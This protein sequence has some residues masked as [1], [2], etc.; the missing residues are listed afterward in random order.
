M[1]T[2]AQM[3]VDIP[4]FADATTFP[5]PMLQYWLTNAY[6]LLS[7]QRWGSL[8]DLGAEMFAAHECLLEARIMAEM[9]NGEIAGTTTGAISSK[10][11]DKVSV[12]FDTSN[13]TE[14]GAGYYNTTVYGMRF[15]KLMRRVGAGPIHLG[16]SGFE[17]PLNSAFAWP[18]PFYSL[19]PNP[20]Q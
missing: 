7:A 4:A 1:I 3:V 2:P 18:G 13:S 9:A 19:Q 16:G 20:S 6:A 8:L 5:Q 12:A 15:W 11:V 14:K 17:N 10:S